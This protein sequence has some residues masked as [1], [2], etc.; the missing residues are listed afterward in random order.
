MQTLSL[1]P[2][3]NAFEIQ[4]SEELLISS[5][6]IRAMFYIFGLPSCWLPYF[7][8]HKPVPED[9]VPPGVNENWYLCSKVLPMGIMYCATPT[10]HQFSGG[11]AIHSPEFPPEGAG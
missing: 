1:L 9:L 11:C 4:P 3:M 2:Q 10:D 5:E 8:L 7:A 6:D